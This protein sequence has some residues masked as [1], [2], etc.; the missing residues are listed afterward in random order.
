MYEEKDLV[1]VARRENN[2]KRTYLVVNRLQ[3]KHIPSVPDE[4]LR[5]FD[6]LA[7]EIKREYREET[8]LLVGF[9]ETATAIGARLSVLLDSYYMQTTREDETGV[10]YLYFSES[11]SHATEQKL[12]KDGLDQAAHLVKR[13][14]FVEDEVT[15]GDTIMKIIRII[16]KEYA[17]MFSFSVASLL[18]GMSRENIEKYA[19][20]NI[21]LH[22]LV[23]TNHEAYSQKALSYRGDGGYHVMTARDG[24][25][26]RIST[27][28]VEGCM[29][30]RHL[31]RGSEYEAACGRLWAHIHED[32]GSVTKKKILV[33]GTEEFMYPAIYVADR[34]QKEGN[35]V[36]CHSTT[37]SPIEVSREQ[38]YPVHE[39]YELVSLYDRERT[40]YLYDIGTYDLAVVLTDS[41][42]VPEEGLATLIRALEACGNGS[43]VCYTCLEDKHE[44][45]LY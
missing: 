5:M 39:R 30:A 2:T 20:E 27:R 16:R 28:D 44:V 34:L 37:R 26:E 36:R 40:T 14:V 1:R 7:E 45:I 31:V 17:G 41:S 25:T 9:A 23:K 42:R 13:I 24:G 10:S 22:Y 12:M 33:L 18:N 11:H 21:A 35:E 6:R 4:T 8:L 43:I 19:K 15:T 3:A 29:N 32:L 38:D